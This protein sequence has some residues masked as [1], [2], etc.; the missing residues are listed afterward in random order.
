MSINREKLDDISWAWGKRVLVEYKTQEPE[1]TLQYFNY[2]END[3]KTEFTFY[4][5]SNVDSSRLSICSN[6]IARV[7]FVNVFCSK[8]QKKTI[9]YCFEKR[10]FPEDVQSIIMEYV[11]HVEVLFDCNNVIRGT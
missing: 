4:F 11:E 1:Q 8:V 6:I 2:L 9:D 3:S 10:G 7:S 5:R